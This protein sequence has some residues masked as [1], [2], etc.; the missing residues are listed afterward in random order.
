MSGTSPTYCDA[1]WSIAVIGMLGMTLIGCTHLNY[2]SANKR[3]HVRV[4]RAVHRTEEIREKNS[5]FLGHH[6]NRPICPDPLQLSVPKRIQAT[7]SATIQH[8]WYQLWHNLIKSFSSYSQTLSKYRSKIGVFYL[9]FPDSF[10]TTKA[11]K[12]FLCFQTENRFK[13]PP[14]RSKRRKYWFNEGPWNAKLSKICR[15]KTA[16]FGNS[17]MDKHKMQCQVNAYLYLDMQSMLQF[18]FLLYSQLGIFFQPYQWTLDQWMQSGAPVQVRERTRTL[19][20]HPPM[21]APFRACFSRRT[22]SV[23]HPA[24]TLLASNYMDP[25]S[26]ALLFRSIFE[27]S[28]ERLLFVFQCSNQWIPGTIFSTSIQ[29]RRRI[30]LWPPKGHIPTGQ[31][32][33]A[34]YWRQTPSASFALYFPPIR[35]L[36]SFVVTHHHNDG[37]RVRCGSPHHQWNPLLAPVSYGALHRMCCSTFSRS[38][39]IFSGTLAPHEREAGHFRFTATVA[40]Q[41]RHACP[42]TR[43][44]KA[45]HALT[46]VRTRP[47]DDR[48]SLIITLIFSFS[49]VTPRSTSIEADRQQ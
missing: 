44:G 9:L 25:R 42:V 31:P 39:H 33:N 47:T 16:I 32:S 17:R 14:P 22:H 40:T 15:V 10:S 3:E 28:K 6:Y 49:P 2:Q 41:Q 37:R 21:S 13:I 35:F 20:G 18:P 48:D 34:C 7:T 1:M 26:S 5:H 8:I 38:P 30:L 27:P 24:C 43:T 36:T 11:V 29:S 23:D 19:T 46:E 12:Q 45:R 4:I